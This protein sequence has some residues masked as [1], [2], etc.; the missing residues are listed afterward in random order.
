[1]A[2][3][4]S[5]KNANTAKS[6]AADEASKTKTNAKAKT[7]RKKETKPK[8]LMYKGK[9]FVRRGNIIYYGNP[10]DKYIVTFVL[11]NFKKVKDIDVAQKVTILLQQNDDYLNPKNKMIKKAERDCLWAAIDIGT[12]WLED[13]LEQG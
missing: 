10:A 1:M 13:A 12:F 4:Q 7:S 3:K 6:A 2:E 8:L 5:P 11:E 9:P